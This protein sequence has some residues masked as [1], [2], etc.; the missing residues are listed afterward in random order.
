MEKLGLSGAAQLNRRLTVL[1]AVDKLDRLGLSGVEQLLGK[2][3]RD[4]S[5]DFTKGAELDR[6]SIV[7]VLE[8][9]D[10]DKDPAD[11]IAS[12]D[13]RL[14]DSPIGQEGR[15]ELEDMQQVFSAAGYE[16][17]R[18]RIDPS[19]IRG[20]AYY[21]GPVF[22]AELLIEA[23]NDE[24][25]LVRFGS[26]GG[27][28]RYDDLVS[29]FRG[30]LIPAT[31]FSIGV[32]RL[33]S[34]L[35]HLGKLASSVAQGPVVVLVLD[36]A[37]SADYQAMVSEL[38]NAK[39]PAELYLGTSGLKAQMKYADKRGASLVIIEGEEERSRG[40]VQIKDLAAGAE[41][42]GTIVSR[43]AWRGARPAQF[44]VSRTGLVEAVK[45]WREQNRA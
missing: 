42:A 24:G 26:V 17:D 1:R 34:A 12:I 8:I 27:G 37:R 41:A 18:I 38:R 5:G 36:R 4:E 14:K 23:R 44:S 21:T 32:S 39:I 3:R 28:G 20:L 16:T 7:D 45:R 30:E 33:Y 19:V 43:E 2:G 9:I 15:Q 25:Q 31:G 10:P 29:R 6:A 40:E 13:L 35:H 11:A 22:E